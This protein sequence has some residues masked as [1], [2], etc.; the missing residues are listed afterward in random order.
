MHH[1]PEQWQAMGQWRDLCGQRIFTLDNGRA[2]AP[3]VVLLH[4]YPTSSWDWNELWALLDGDFRLVALDLLGFGFSAKPCPH[5]Y[6]ISE[7][8]DIVEALVAA[9]ALPRFHVLAHDYG[10]TVA[11]ELLTRQNALSE[12][13]WLSCCLL[14]G[15]LFPETHHA[16]LIQKMML[17]PLGP[18][19]TGLMKEKQL[20]RTMGKLFGPHTQPSPE[21]SHH[22]WELINFNNGRRALN[23]L[24]NYI[25]QR[26]LHRERWV[27]ALQQSKV[28][29]GLI[30]GAVDPVSGAHMV[31]RF[32]EVVGEPAFRR[33]L[34]TIGH[35]P[36]IEAAAEVNAAFR[37]FVQQVEGHQARPHNP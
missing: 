32:L 13:R 16:R 4:G 7:Q 35:Y 37:D 18:L 27:G 14:N 24:I 31:A 36:Q 23:K 33:S 26:I 20:H 15:G 30:N 11:Q 8:A 25:P 9:L 3:V 28:P 1:S 12:P 2:D 34:P 29:L 17:S 22:F 10:D 19:V 5:P 6:L 21:L